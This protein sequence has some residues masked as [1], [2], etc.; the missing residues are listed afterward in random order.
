MHRTQWTASIV[1]FLLAAAATSFL[2][3]RD[4]VSAAKQ[5]PPAYGPLA[6]TQPEV[7]PA[8]SATT[9]ADKPGPTPGASTSADKLGPAP[10]A[11]TSTTMPDPSS[12]ETIGALAAAHYFQTYLNIGFIADGKGKGTY[13][14][15]EARKV[16]RTV[17]SVVDSVDRQLETLA[18]RA[19]EKEDRNSLEQ[20]RA[21]SALLRQQGRELQTYWDSGKDQDADRYESDRKK[22]YGAINK[23]IGIGP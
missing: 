6:A 18:K 11:S 4:T 13:S 22:L 17:L 2:A 21:I 10:G 5:E 16:L 8:Q 1:A 9:S 14:D 7:P 23:L 15:E 12:L 19:M 3:R 20:M